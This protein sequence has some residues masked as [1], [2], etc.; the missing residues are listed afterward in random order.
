METLVTRGVTHVGQPP[1]KVISNMVQSAL[2]AL[3]WERGETC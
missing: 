2:A 3:P 1:L